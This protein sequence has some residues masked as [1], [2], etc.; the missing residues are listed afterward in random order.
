MWGLGEALGLKLSI[1]NQF[2]RVGDTPVYT[3][4]GAAPGVPIYWTSFKDGEPTGEYNTT[5]PGHVVESN[6]TA[7]LVAGGPWT[8]SDV[9]VWTKQVL[10]QDADGNNS[11]AQLQFRVAPASAQASPATGAPT[12]TGSFWE[13]PLFS[14]GD[15]EVTPGLAF[16]GFG[17]FYLATKKR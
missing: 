2:Q 17:I 13:N 5:Y 8:D 9:G 15:F 4:I 6:G 10:V 14:I 1:D 12:P 16:L 3:L 7:R 11:I